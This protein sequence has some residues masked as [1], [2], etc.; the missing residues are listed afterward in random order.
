M[1]FSTA[2]TVCHYYTEHTFKGSET[3]C[4]DIFTVYPVFIGH[5]LQLHNN[6]SIIIIQE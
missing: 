2:L 6:N 5:A 3:I 4:V 1:F